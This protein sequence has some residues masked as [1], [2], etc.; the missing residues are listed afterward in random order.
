MPHRFDRKMRRMAALK[1]AASLVD[2]SDEE[3]DDS[4]DHRCF[5]QEEAAL[6]AAYEAERFLSFT[7]DRSF[8]AAE[9]VTL[10]QRLQRS[11]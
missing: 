6:L 9:S 8:T 10:T 3:P 4:E 1:E 11:G 7:G 5:E 2:S